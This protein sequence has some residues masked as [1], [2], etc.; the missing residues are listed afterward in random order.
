MSA[1]H[2]S[3]TGSTRW[4]PSPATVPS[5]AHSGGH[6]ATRWA[7]PATIGPA[8]SDP[9]Q[10]RNHRLARILGALVAVA[11]FVGGSV[12]LAAQSAATN[13]EKA[14][15]TTATTYLTALAAGDAEGALATLEAEPQNR[16]LLSES[17]LKAAMA[18]S[19]LTDPT[20]TAVTSKDGDATAAVTYSLGG[21]P[22]TTTLALKGDGKMAWKIADGVS[23]LMVTNVQGLTVNGATITQ[24]VNPVFPGTYTAV[25]TT[26][27]IKLDGTTSAVVSDPS[28]PVSTLEVTPALSEKG[29]T[30]ARAAAKA[31]FDAC[32]ATKV[33]APAGCPWALD[34]TNVTV[35]P[36]SV[37]YKLLNDPWTAWTPTLD[38]ATMTAKG[39]AHYTVD[40]TATITVGELSGD[41]TIRIDRDTLPVVDL[42][43]NPMKVVWQ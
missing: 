40:A 18:A 9:G 10:A 27:L 39:I 16:V 28:V 31:A 35:A 1:P 5:A 30:D 12:W 26:D 4:T 13:R 15:R 8:A 17:V 11:L 34:E 29:V 38:L 33:S 20:V 37:R 43:S 22:V 42:T 6:G 36:D 21:K 25:A 24:P 2:A 41:G 3:A 19:P 7:A 14:I 23:D 32:L